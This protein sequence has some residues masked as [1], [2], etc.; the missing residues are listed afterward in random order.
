MSFDEEQFGWC[1]NPLPD[2]QELEVEVKTGKRFDCGQPP[3][4]EPVLT[5]PF[6]RTVSFSTRRLRHSSISPC[7]D[8]PEGGIEH[9]QGGGILSATRLFLMMSMVVGPAC[10]RHDDFPRRRRRS[11]AANRH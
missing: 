9:F 2:E 10:P 4:G 7:S 11:R 6:S 8:A 5:R 3:Q 1:Q